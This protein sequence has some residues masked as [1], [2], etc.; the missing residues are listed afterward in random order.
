MKKILLVTPIIALMIL[1]SC[2]T[3]IWG[4]DVDMEYPAHSHT[5]EYENDTFHIAFKLNTK[6]IE[7]TIYN[8]SNDGIKIEWDQVSFSINGKTHRIIHK[9]TGLIRITEVQPPT[10]IPPKSNLVDYLV[11]TDKIY[12]GNNPISWSTIMKIDDLFPIN[13]YGNKKIRNKI[14]LLKGARITVFLPYFI[15]NKYVSQY[16]DLII[17]DIQPISNKKKNK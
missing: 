5:L 12:V 17:K 4:Y 10:T 7:F 9:E 11:P 14:S 13:D 1:Q 8:K 16:Y 2:S 15:G 6:S 3:K